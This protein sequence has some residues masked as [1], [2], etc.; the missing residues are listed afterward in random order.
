MG[1]RSMAILEII[2][3]AL[4]CLAAQPWLAAPRP[5]PGANWQ[6]QGVSRGGVTTFAKPSP[7]GHLF[8]HGS[9]YAP[10][11]HISELLAETLDDR[12]AT[13]WVDKLLE[14]RSATWSGR[15]SQAPWGSHVCEDVS[16][17]VFD[18]PWPVSDREALMHRTLW[19]T[20]ANKTAR[21]SF[22]P[23]EELRS[24]PVGRN[25]VRAD[26]SSEFEF[27]AHG[28]ELGTRISL[29][30]YVD[31]KGI[32]PVALINLLNKD[33]AANTIAGLLRKVRRDEVRRLVLRSPLAR[34][35]CRGVDLSQWGS[36]VAALASG[37]SSSWAEW[38]GFGS[39]WSAPASVE[40]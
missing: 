31:P 25:R 7:S 12:H 16:F 3:I 36:Q 38:L 17:Q 30:G 39:F 21:L 40:L 32:L 14:I 1:P 29:M 11:V 10:G 19:T 8:F 18:G 22:E 20:R 15:R 26:V 24:F 13:E 6:F 2:L 37:Q 23:I 4:P 35:A 34:G 5:P 27:V 28:Q 9:L 33:W